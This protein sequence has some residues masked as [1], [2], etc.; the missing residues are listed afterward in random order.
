[1]S[2]LIKNGYSVTYDIVGDQRIGEF[3]DGIWSIAE[4]ER[5][6]IWLGTENDGAIRLTFNSWPNIEDV[7]IERFGVEH[8]LPPG[9]V[10]TSLLEGK[11]YFTP[12]KGLY[13]FDEDTKKFN[14]TNVFG[15]KA[16]DNNLLVKF[17][18]P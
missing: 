2:I 1:M 3:R 8:G 5:G 9:Q 7:I 17:L 12:V 18:P 13:T 4:D 16:M 15:K 11:I 6:R 10:F 14:K